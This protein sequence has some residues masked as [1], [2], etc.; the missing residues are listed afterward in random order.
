LLK[1]LATVITLFTVA[2]TS[3]TSV[4]AQNNNL[5]VRGQYLVEQVAMCADCHSPRNEQGEFDRTHWLQGAPIGFK[6]IFPM[7]AWADIAPSIAGIGNEGST[8]KEEAVVKLL[9]TGL[10]SQGIPARPPMPTYRLSHSDALAVVA[11]LKSLNSN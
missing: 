8:Q 6:P 5:I 11:Y 3:V 10:N 7:P 4:T 1:L 2:T 9:E